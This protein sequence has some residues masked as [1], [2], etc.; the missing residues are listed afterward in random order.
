MLVGL[1]ASGKQYGTARSNNSK[2]IRCPR[3]KWAQHFKKRYVF[4]IR[5]WKKLRIYAL[6]LQLKGETHDWKHRWPSIVP[7]SWL[8]VLTFARCL[9]LE[10]TGMIT[11][12]LPVFLKKGVWLLCY[13]NQLQT[14]RFC[15]SIKGLWVRSDGGWGENNDFENFG[16][17]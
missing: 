6:R 2:T 14:W 1:L 15:E 11:C 3:I 8:T 13:G 7:Y 5:K 17:N 12:I 4:W 10:L 16:R 9:F